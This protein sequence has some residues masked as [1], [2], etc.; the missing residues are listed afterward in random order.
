MLTRCAKVW[1]GCGKPARMREK[2]I[3]RLR[4]VAVGGNCRGADRILAG[5]LDGAPENF[6]GTVP[7]EPHERVLEDVYDRHPI[8]RNTLLANLFSQTNRAV[9]LHVSPRPEGRP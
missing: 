6:R 3:E 4:S 5:Q 2:R 8:G 7:C 9:S 1:R